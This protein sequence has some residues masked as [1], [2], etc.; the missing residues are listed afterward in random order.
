METV[1][2]LHVLRNQLDRKETFLMVLWRENDPEI[3]RYLARVQRL[4][5]QY[6]PLKSFS[7]CL[8]T[9]PTAAARFGAF[10]PPVIVVYANGTMVLKLS[11][12]YDSTPVR[13]KL[14]S[15]YGT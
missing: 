7:V 3:A 10:Q 6:P 5:R 15:I 8:D 11:D 12:T 13:A 4:V 14:D 1:D 2:D 9:H